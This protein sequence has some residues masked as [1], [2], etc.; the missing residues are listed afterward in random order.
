MWSFHPERNLEVGHCCLV[1]KLSCASELPG[2]LVK[3]NQEGL[4]W[5]WALAF[6]RFPSWF[7]CIPKFENYWLKSFVHPVLR[8]ASTIKSNCLG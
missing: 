1:L 6:N 7:T 2:E 5:A 3:T 8:E 4:D